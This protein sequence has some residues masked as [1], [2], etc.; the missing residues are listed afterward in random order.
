[1]LETVNT[2]R[3]TE[4]LEPIYASKYLDS[5]CLDHIN[6]VIHH[7]IMGHEG[8]D[9]ST[10]SDRIERYGQWRGVVGKLLIST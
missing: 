3:E 5:A 1:M 7:E 8:S 10:L 6:D 4:P 9:G 2:L